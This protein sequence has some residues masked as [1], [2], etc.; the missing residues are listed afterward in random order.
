MLSVSIDIYIYN[1]SLCIYYVEHVYMYI[2]WDTNLTCTES[3]EETCVTFRRGKHFR[4]TGV[5]NSL[6]LMHA[7]LKYMQTKYINGCIYI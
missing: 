5:W 3:I 7:S 1:T 4:N 2:C 6:P